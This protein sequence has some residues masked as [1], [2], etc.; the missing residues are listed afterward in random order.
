[1]L[2]AEEVA[3][4]VAAVEGRARAT[5]DAGALR[6]H[7]RPGSNI[8]LIEQ[9]PGRNALRAAEATWGFETNWNSKLLFNTRIESAIHGSATWRDAV[10]NGRCIIPA[11]AFFEP[12]A[13]ETARSARTGRPVKRAYQFSLPGAEPLLLAGVQANG[14]CSIVTCEPNRWVSPVHNR[15]PLVLRFEEVPTWLSSDWPA[16]ADRSAIELAVQP[17]RPNDPPEPSQLALF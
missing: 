16:L 1:M 6:P 7:A 13:T 9:D 11:V 3:E 12:H 14:R 5:L 4:V 8:S 10:Q 17:E 2:T 15:M